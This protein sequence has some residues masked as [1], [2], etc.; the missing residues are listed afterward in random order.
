MFMILSSKSCYKLVKIKL[1]IVE[2]KNSKININLNPV[3]TIGF[4]QKRF[5]VD[6]AQENNIVVF[7]KKREKL[8]YRELFDFLRF[9][10]F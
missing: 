7:L 6:R 1:V 4:Q 2:L 10:L 3:H 5:Q 8:K 9:H